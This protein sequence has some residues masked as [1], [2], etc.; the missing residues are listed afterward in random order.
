M[1]TAVVIGI[2]A[3]LYVVGSVAFGLV[4]GRGIHKADVRE[5]VGVG[6]DVETE[7][8]VSPPGA[9][10]QIRKGG[11]AIAGR[12]VCTTVYDGRG[13]AHLAHPTTAGVTVCGRPFQLAGKPTGRSCQDCSAGAGQANQLL[14]GA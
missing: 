9:V 8:V 10:V 11:K 12:P 2:G 5:G 4:V 3:L 6:V 1:T 14:R 7:V 13:T